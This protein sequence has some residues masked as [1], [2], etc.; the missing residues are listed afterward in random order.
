MARPPVAN[1]TKPAAKAAGE[2]AKPIGYVN[3]SVLGAEGAVVLRSNRGFSVFDNEHCSVEEKALIEL[4]KAHGGTATVSATLTI[5]VAKDKPT[6]ID[7]S[8][9]PVIPRVAA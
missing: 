1:T 9:I 2:K 5:I 8:A 6:S 3:W 7:V 4:A